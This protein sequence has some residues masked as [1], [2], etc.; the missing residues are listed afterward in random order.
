MKTKVSVNIILSAKNKTQVVKNKLGKTNGFSL[1]P[2]TDSIK[3]MILWNMSRWRQSCYLS[4]SVCR[5]NSGSSRWSAPC[6]SV[7]AHRGDR[8]LVLGLFHTPSAQRFLQIKQN[9]YQ[10]TAHV[11]NRHRIRTI[12]VLGIL[13]SLMWCVSCWSRMLGQDIPQQRITLLCA[14]KLLTNG[15]SAKQWS[16]IW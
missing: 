2:P 7:H 10:T 4:G 1:I 5:A 3:I 13:T 11:I 9:N 6:R 16:L 12:Q 8:S 14:F 15:I